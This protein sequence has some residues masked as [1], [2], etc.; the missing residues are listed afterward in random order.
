M[1]A[2]YVKI[3]SGMLDA[4]KDVA[5]AMLGFRTRDEMEDVFSRPLVW[6]AVKRLS[7]ALDEVR[8]NKQPDEFALGHAIELELLANFAAGG[9]DFSQMF[10][11]PHFHTL[12]TSELQERFANAWGTEA[13]VT[14][15]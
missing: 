9:D 4:Y 2:D 13:P 1:S 7:G 11:D 6:A 5:Q 10:Y 3:D 15:D 14:I 8:Q 12:P